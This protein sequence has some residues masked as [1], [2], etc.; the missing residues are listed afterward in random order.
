M[1]SSVRC[2]YAPRRIVATHVASVK[3]LGNKLTNKFGNLCGN[4]CESTITS[5]LL[6]LT[7]NVRGTWN[8]APLV[9]ITASIRRVA[10]HE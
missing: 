10:L 1:T 7:V 6:Y 5:G 4:M 9:A 3:G 8:M 2:C